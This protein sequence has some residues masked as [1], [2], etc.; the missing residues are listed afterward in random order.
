MNKRI[1]GIVLT[2]LCLAAGGMYAM[3][4]GAY[5]VVPE[6][7]ASMEARGAADITQ[8]AR[9]TEPEPVNI[10][11]ADAALLDT[12][13]GI[14]PAK[15][16]AILAYRKSHGYFRHVEDLM[17]VSGIKEGTFSKLEGLVTVGELPEM[18]RTGGW[19]GVLPE[20]GSEELLLPAIALQGGL[21]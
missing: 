14:G 3:Q 11:T 16:A 12:L 4:H 2:V 15:A 21:P 7:E 17:K 18:E 13:P 1:P 10:N 5:F 20:I 19:P 8:E 6:E 9:G